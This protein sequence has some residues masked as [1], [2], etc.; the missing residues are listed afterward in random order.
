MKLSEIQN[1]KPYTV[2]SSSGVSSP[3]S[4]TVEPMAQSKSLWDKTLDIGTG[5]SNFFGGKG[6]SDLAGATIAKTMA[7]PEEKPFVQFPTGKEVAG[8]A[9]Q[10]G[11]NFVPGAGELKGVGGLAKLGIRTG[12]GLGTGYALDVGSKLQQDKPTG[13]AVT[14]GIGTAVGGA[15]PVAG[16]GIGYA[17]RVIGR[18]FK[19]LGSGISGVSTKTLDEILNNPKVA[20]KATDKLAKSGN[21]K[22]IEENAKT[23]VNGVGKIQNEASSAYRS[24]LDKLSQTDIKPDKLKA[25]VEG[26]LTK[27]KIGIGADGVTDFNNADFLDPKIQQRAEA[28]IN[29]VSKQE[30]MSGTGIRKLMDIVDNAKFKSA[31]DGER[32]AFNA[33]IIDLKNGLKEGV[34]ASTDKL[35]E[36]NKKY[37]ADMQLSEAAQHIFGN[38]DY[39]NV[40]EVAKAAKSLENLFNQKGLDP[41][42]IDNFLNRI[43]IK[44]SDFRASEAVRQISNKEPM[45]P[46]TPGFNFGEIM[47]TATGSIMTPETIRNIT[48]KTGLAKEKLTPLLNGLKSLSPALQKVVIQALLQDQ[49]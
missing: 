15:L 35:G 7:K 24:G 6:I 43:G 13:E 48:I 38:V 4:F 12:L 37:S 29:K 44:P 32:Q 40:S 20:Q 3:S 25:G 23:L 10:L 42:T 18:L 16:A 14:P 47:R 39:K 45:P 1:N 36:I 5:V 41:Q 27:H 9:L 30:D 46:N 31:P 26:A 19:G 22:I 2:L 49:Q 33:F 11:A 21:F 34:N 17:S 8:S 28:V